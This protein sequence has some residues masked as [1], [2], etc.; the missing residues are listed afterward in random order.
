MVTLS[1]TWLLIGF[2]GQGMFSLRFLVQW[3]SSERARRSVVPLAFW[4]FSL[5]GGALLLLYAVHRRDPVFIVGQV[6]GLFIY[7]RN[8]HLIR[9]R[10]RQEEDEPARQRDPA[11]TARPERAASQALSG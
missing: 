7:A 5:G 3:I 11:G 10:G 8:L 6:T 9:R 1:T 4:Y 2:A